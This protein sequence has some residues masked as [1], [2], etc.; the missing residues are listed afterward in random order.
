MHQLGFDVD[1]LAWQLIW[2]TPL[3]KLVKFSKELKP[4]SSDVIKLFQQKHFWANICHLGYFFKAKVVTFWASFHK[5]IF[6][7]FSLK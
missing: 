4:G 3:I 7:H 1:Y 6:L 2:L 5:S